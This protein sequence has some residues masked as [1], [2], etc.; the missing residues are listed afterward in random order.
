[1]TQHF[2]LS[3]K[4]RTLSLAKVMRLSDD[5]AYDTFKAIRWPSGE[6][7]CPR[8]GCLAIYVYKSRKIF[9]CKECEAQ[10]SI[11]TAT[12][13]ASRKLSFRDL[14]AAI[15]IFV[16]GAKGYS[17]LQLSR[18]LDCQYKTAFVLTHKL[19]QA[20]AAGMES[21][22]LRGEIEIDGA[23]FGVST[24]EQKYITGRFKNASLGVMQIVALAVVPV[25]HGRDPRGLR[26]ACIRR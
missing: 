21:R 8:C 2:L 19:R 25:V 20:M 17:A 26:S 3:A 9:K 6:P 15:A 23:Y 7:H 10:F 12:L 24:P 4:A 1:M 14:L 5:E 16:N 18:D 22:M 11:T 13:F